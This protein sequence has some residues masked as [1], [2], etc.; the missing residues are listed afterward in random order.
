MHQFLRATEIVDWRDPEIVTLARTIR[1]DLDG[2]EAIARRAFEWVRD[3]IKHAGD[4]QLDEVT[5]IASDVL[6][7]GSGY[8]F[9]KSHLLAALLRANRIPAGFCYQRLRADD[10]GRQF[11]LHG[12]N[13]VWLPASGWYRVDP[14]GNKD[15][16]DAQFAP[17][18][19]RLAFSPSCEGEADLPG[20]LADPLQNVVESLRVHANAIV[21]VE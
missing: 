16:V 18:A 3:E 20:V 19:E 11:C 8:C 13:A 6:R 5:C 7:V 14:R 1:G 10:E 21:I 9:A 15:G 4:W 12:F 17:P 2:T